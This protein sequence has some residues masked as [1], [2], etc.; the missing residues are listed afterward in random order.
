MKT[1]QVSTEM[2]EHQEFYE[3]EEEPIYSVVLGT[4]I[5]QATNRRETVTVGDVERRGGIYML[6]QPRTG[7]TSLLVHSLI[8]QDMKH[9]HGLCFIDPHG[10]GIEDVL[11]LVP[12]NR[13]D[14]VI[15]LDP[16]DEE[17]AFGL[18]LFAC[19]NPQSRKQ[20]SRTIN[21]VLQVFGK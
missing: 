14:D 7:K 5:N 11:K 21:Y 8:L 17:Y 20:I 12:E 19:K 1:F 2:S 6:G 4:G 18:N 16:L 3:A 9:G 10:D 13:L 15:L